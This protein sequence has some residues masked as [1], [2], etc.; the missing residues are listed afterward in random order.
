MARACPVL[1]ET[2][3]DEIPSV[4]RPDLQCTRVHVHSMTCCFAVPY[5]LDRV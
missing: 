2:A 4:R 3:P 5:S 1:V